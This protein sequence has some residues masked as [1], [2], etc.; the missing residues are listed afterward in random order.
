MLIVRILRPDRMTSALTNFIR[1]ILPHGKS[2]VE[3]DSDV[4]SFQVLEQSYED[5]TPLIPLYFILSPGSDVASDMDKLALKCGMVKE[6][7]YFNISLGKYDCDMIWTYINKTADIVFL[8]LFTLSMHSPT[9]FTNTLTNTPYL[10]HTHTQIHTH[11]HSHSHTQSHTH[12]TTGQGQD[13][14]AAERLEAGSSQGFWIFLNNI[15]LMPKWLPVL[16]KKVRQLL[17]SH[18]SVLFHIFLWDI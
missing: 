5:C 4:S 18:C 3:C 13:V 1:D 10:S 2:F 9:H 7:T 14:V 6:I 12:T 8:T 11:T 15:H 17:H 16:E